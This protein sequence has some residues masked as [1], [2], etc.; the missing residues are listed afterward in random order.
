MFSFSR[1]TEGTMEIKV[2]E[3]R[4]SIIGTECGINTTNSKNDTGKR[5]NRM[6]MERHLITLIFSFRFFLL[7][8]AKMPKLSLK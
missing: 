6:L 2:I 3:N 8:K 5:G 4:G 7:Q 1:K